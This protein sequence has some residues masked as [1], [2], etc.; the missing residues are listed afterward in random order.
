M[1]HGKVSQSW[2]VNAMMRRPDLPQHPWVVLSLVPAHMDGMSHSGREQLTQGKRPWIWGRL[3]TG[4]EGGTEDWDGWMVLLTQRTW[5]WAISGREWRTGK[6]GVLQSMGSQGVRHKR[7]NVRDWSLAG[8]VR[9]IKAEGK[10][11]LWTIPSPGW[12]CKSISI[13][14]LEKMADVNATLKNFKG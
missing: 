8:R 6:P 7:L 9:A 13:F 1:K 2:K 4:G 11:E 12:D 5:V 3:R 10:W 14:H